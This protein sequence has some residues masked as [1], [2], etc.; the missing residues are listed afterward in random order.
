[1]VLTILL[2]HDFI[3]DNEGRVWSKGVVDYN[4]LKRYLNV[5]DRVVL[6]ARI[7]ENADKNEFNDYKLEVSGENIDFVELPYA[8]TSGEI[9]K[10]YFNF[11]KKF[12]EAINVADRV[13]IRGPS[14]ISLMLYDMVYKKKKFAV[15]FVMGAEQILTEKNFIRKIVNKYLNNRAKKM[16]LKANGVA[17]VTKEK[18]QLRYP[19]FSIKYGKDEQ[20]FDSYYSSIDLKDSNYFEKDWENYNK[21]NE[22][23]IVHTG[24]MQNDRKGQKRLIDAVSKI[25]EDGYKVKIVFIGEGLLLDNLKEYVKEKKIADKVEFTGNISNNQVFEYLKK[26]DLFVLPS[27]SEGLPRSIIEAMATSLPCVSSNVDGI[28]ELIDEAYLS[29]YDDI[30]GY[31]RNIKKFLDDF[32][33]MKRERKK[34]FY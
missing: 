30:D 29:E 15:E 9:I 6:C 28:P 31:R 21:P 2:E 19:S 23:L 32:K 24:S 10:N 13:I 12:K 4:Y 17:Y 20:H 26:S 7:R 1:M 22:F 25:I 11:R 8:L 16:C 18:L 33:L 34:K 3:K 27:S 5:F 14:V